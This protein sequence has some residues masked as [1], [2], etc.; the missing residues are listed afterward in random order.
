M[1]FPEFLAEKAKAYPSQTV[2][3]NAEVTDLIEEGGRVVGVAGPTPDGPLEIH[4]DLVI[5]CDG[6]AST[7]RAKAGLQVRDLGSPIDVL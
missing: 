3:M 7:V 4:A 1:G 5:G 2:M 6:R